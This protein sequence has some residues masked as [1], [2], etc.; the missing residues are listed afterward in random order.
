MTGYD[1]DRHHRRSI[2]LEGYDYTQPGAYFVTIVTHRRE[3][4]FGDVAKGKMHLNALGQIVQAEWLRTAQ[5]R[6]N[7]ELDAF[8]IMPNHVHGILVIHD[9]AE[10]SV[11]ARRRRAPTDDC[12]PTDVTP[13]VEPRRAPTD[14]CTPTDVTPGIEP[15]RRLVGPP[16]GSLGAIMAQFKSI[17]TKRINAARGTPGAGVWQR[18][19]YERIIRTQRELQMVRRYI[20]GNPARW[21]TDTENPHEPCGRTRRTRGET[22]RSR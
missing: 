18:N 19:Y 20:L 12:T 17:C 4:L 10:S 3:C 15:R 22:C 6:P 16:S 13:G 5:V 8:V 1:P 21:L 9:R 11:G 14:D 2:R 7:V